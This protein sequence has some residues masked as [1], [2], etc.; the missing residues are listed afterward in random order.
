VTVGATSVG[1]SPPMYVG[2]VDPGSTITI[3][4]ETLSLS[5]LTRAVS[6]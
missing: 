3:G 6:R 5:M 1:Q 2:G 4:R